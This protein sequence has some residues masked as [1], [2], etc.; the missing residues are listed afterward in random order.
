MG[1]YGVPLLFGPHDTSIGSPVMT[2]TFTQDM[3]MIAITVLAT[4]VGQMFLGTLLFGQVI[5]RVQVYS[6]LYAVYLC[7]FVTRATMLSLLAI[8]PPQN[9]ENIDKLMDDILKQ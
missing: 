6:V 9:F 1:V 5:R 2:M 8:D 4:T 7:A 3:L